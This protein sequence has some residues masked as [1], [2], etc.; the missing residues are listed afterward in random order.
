VPLATL[1]S[2]AERHRWFPYV[3]S[4]PLHLTF[5]TPSPY[6]KTVRCR[7]AK[8]RRLL[9]RS[10]TIGLYMML[11]PPPMRWALDV[12]RFTRAVDRGR[13]RRWGWGQGRENIPR[14][15]RGHPSIFPE[16]CSQWLFPRG[17]GHNTALL[18]SPLEDLRSSQAPVL[19]NH[20]TPP[21]LLPRPGRSGGS[22]WR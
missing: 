20:R 17:W 18:R 21:G 1:K 15:V 2:R 10:R 14:P 19:A 9:H 16:V 5:H 3:G 4:G 11:T 13:Y 6:A 8:P 7:A 22:A 12:P